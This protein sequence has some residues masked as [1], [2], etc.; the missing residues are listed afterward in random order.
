[1]ASKNKDLLACYSFAMGGRH[2][3]YVGCL[4]KSADYGSRKVGEREGQGDTS[5][6]NTYTKGRR[7]PHDW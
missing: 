4:M 2:K 5:N 7:N 3:H 1:M 6:V